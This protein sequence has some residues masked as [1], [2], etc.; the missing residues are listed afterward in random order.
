MGIKIL[1]LEKILK[2]ASFVGVTLLSGCTYDFNTDMIIEDSQTVGVTGRNFEERYSEERIVFKE[3]IVYLELVSTE[4]PDYQSLFENSPRS[5]VNKFGREVSSEYFVIDGVLYLK[6]GENDKHSL[7]KKI[8][9]V[10]HI[11][12]INLE[13]RDDADREGMQDD[14]SYEGSS[15]QEGERSQN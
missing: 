14:G 13:D 10:D 6:V 1:N 15:G 5:L 11:D 2:I 3:K 12:Y 4:N 8:N 7:E 9:V